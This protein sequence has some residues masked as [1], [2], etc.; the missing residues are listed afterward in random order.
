MTFGGTLMF[1]LGIYLEQVMPKTFG[2]QKKPCF[3]FESKKKPV[4]SNKVDKSIDEI[5]G[6]YFET[7]YLDQ[8]SYEPINR[9]QSEKE[10]ND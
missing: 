4:K 9:E 10:A 1:L 2:V 7:K 8:N 3:C 6:K 5:R